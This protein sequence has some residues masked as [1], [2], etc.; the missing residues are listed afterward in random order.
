MKLAIFILCLTYSPLLFALSG[1]EIVKRA[2]QLRFIN[3]D[4][5]YLVE[6][7]DFRGSSVQ[8]TKYKVF[9]TGTHSSLVET[10]FPER[11][12]GRKLLMKEDDLWFY[13]PDIKRPTRVSLQQKLTGEVA[14]GDIARTNFGDDYSVEI[15]GKEKLDGVD[16]YHLVLKKKKDEVTYPE[17]EYWVNQA[18]FVPLKAIFKSDGGKPLKTAIY[19]DLKVFFGHKIL[20]KIEIV[21][22][23]NKNQ[24]SILTF[25]GYKKENINESFFNK[26]SLNN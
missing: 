17:I 13:T 8:K 4:N 16:S 2:D 14:N 12:A 21:N 10:T 11:Q 15:K 26:E 20:T 25:T 22:A 19:K 5:S 24:K 6:V 23:I 1:L 7:N 3:T 9:S 18:T